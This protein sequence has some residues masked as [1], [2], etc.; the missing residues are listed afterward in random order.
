MQEILTKWE[1]AN[2]KIF[3]KYPS[4]RPADLSILE[5]ALEEVH[6]PKDPLLLSPKASKAPPG[7][8]KSKKPQKTDKEQEI[9]KFM[10]Q[11]KEKEADIILQAKIGKE[12]YQ[13]K[14]RKEEEEAQELER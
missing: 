8:K 9:D 14:L 4:D 13:A 10:Q 7:P 11:I 5:Q 12:A 6:K 2:N 1:D 3:D